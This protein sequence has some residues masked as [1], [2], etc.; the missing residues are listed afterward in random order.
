MDSR[1]HLSRSSLDTS[2]VVYLEYRAISHYR[3]VYLTCSL[4]SPPLQPFLLSPTSLQISVSCKSALAF[5]FLFVYQNLDPLLLSSFFFLF[6]FLLLLFS[7]CF[8]PW[9]KLLIF[10]LLINILPPISG[11]SSLP[12]NQFS[13]CWLIDLPTP[14]RSIN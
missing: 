9:P 5:L 8:I 10:Y 3:Q 6:L 12:I 4:Y 1:N 14:R 7:S 13:F 2:D 11:P